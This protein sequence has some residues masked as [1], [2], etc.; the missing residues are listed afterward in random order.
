MQVVVT[1]RN[2]EAT[3]ALREHAVAKLQRV[4]KFM[5]RPIE[6]HVVLAVVKHRHV[7]EVT[8]MANRMTFNATEE[9]DDLYS[10]IDLAISKIERQVKKDS[11]KK[12]SRKYGVTTPE[13]RPE[14][15]ARRPKITRERVVV[16]PMSVQEAVLELD[17]RQAE[18]LLFQNADSEALN[19]LYRRKVG[20][21]IVIEPEVE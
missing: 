20:G 19:V 3:E 9:T 18:F 16:K 1:F 5:R 21:Y 14:A 15:P 8:V 7:A 4:Q 12:Q 13:A 2:I 10:A 6:A 11:G 17:T